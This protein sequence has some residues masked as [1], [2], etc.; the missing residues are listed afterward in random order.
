MDN[1]IISKLYTMY[2]RELYLYLYSLC[3]NSSMSE[4]LLQET[5]LKAMLSLNET[6]TNMRAWLY[7]VAR[8]LCFN[9][10]KQEKRISSLEVNH[11][12]QIDESADMIRKILLEERAQHLYQALSKLGGQ[13]KEVLTLQ[14]FGGL[15]QKEIAE[16]LYLTPENVRVI[17]YRAKRE[18]RLYLEE[19][20]YD[21]S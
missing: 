2:G 20:D 16:V 18:L 17:S 6:H 19:V 4:D 3:H 15:S 10:L 21:I 11:E 8:N 13:R 5:F 12:M 9:L 14:Y 7:L 1:Q